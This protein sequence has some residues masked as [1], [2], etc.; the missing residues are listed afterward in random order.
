MKF[1]I[2]F[3]FLNWSLVQSQEVHTIYVLTR[4]NF[5]SNKYKN[6]TEKDSIVLYKDKT[7]KR[8]QNYWGFDEL[9]NKTFVGKWSFS[10]RLL[11]LE[12]QKK[13]DSSE[14][15]VINDVQAI[16]RSHLKKYKKINYN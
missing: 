10:K 7:F 16:N 6:Y 8:I 14:D 15:V 13:Q 9:D 5:Y 11:F 12:I 2:F 4:K 1:L 3:L